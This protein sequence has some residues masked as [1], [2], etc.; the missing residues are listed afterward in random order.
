MNMQ[1]RQKTVLVEAKLLGVTN[2]SV[3]IEVEETQGK[4]GI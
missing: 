2:K 3:H 4:G 1:E